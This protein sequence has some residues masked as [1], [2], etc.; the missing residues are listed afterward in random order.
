MDSP[1]TRYRKAL[2]RSLGISWRIED[3]L[4]DTAHFDLGRPLLPEALAQ[5]QG[6][7]ALRPS[8]QRTL[9]QIR[10]HSYLCLFGLVEEFILPFV[11]DYARG[12]LN[13]DDF[14][15]RALLQF[16]CEEA[17]HI[18]LFKRFT[19]RFSED[20]GTPCAVI[21]PA[22]SIVDAVLSH[23]PL[24][25][26]LMVLHIEWMTQAHYRDAVRDDLTLDPSFVSLLKH[27]WL[28]E[29]QHARLDALIVDQLASQSDD[30]AVRRAIS[31]YHCIVALLENGLRAQVE[32][33]LDALQTAIDRPLAQNER[34]EIRTVQERAYRYTFITSGAEHPH[35]RASYA[36]L[37]QRGERAS[38]TSGAS[39]VSTL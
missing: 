5:V 31:D 36:K 35:F 24:A 34:N 21:G 19:A 10:A 26:G 4:P 14:E 15:V 20:F 3:V 22:Q 32:L 1:Q 25:V 23:H 7:R 37:A 27:H 6:L 39:R 2:E 17:K 33:D 38:T 11:T 30:D 13:E 29:S 12:R 8:E 9:N 16:A 28:E 18:H